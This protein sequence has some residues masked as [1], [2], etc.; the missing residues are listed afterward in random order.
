MTES[1]S[2]TN[3][4]GVD[5][6]ACRIC[7]VGHASWFIQTAGLNILLDPI[8]SERAS[9]FRNAGP[10]RVND[11]G[12]AFADLPPIDAVLVTHAHYDHLDLATL[13][14]LASSR[15]AIT[16][17][18]SPPKPSIGTIASRLVRLP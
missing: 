15:C 13:S 12:I 16:M 3:T 5:G 7:Y 1:V 4:P 8:W 2:A 11:P 17:R 6:A 9:P 14:R 10:K 18:R